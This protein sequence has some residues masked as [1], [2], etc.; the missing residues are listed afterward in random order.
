M[1]FE[2][3]CIV[4][5]QTD[6]Q[7]EIAL[8]SPVDKSTARVTVCNNLS[9]SKQ[10]DPQLDLGVEACCSTAHPLIWDTPL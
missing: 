2:L 9:V 3:N 4:F 8:I 10:L 1:L 6:L 5:N 7:V